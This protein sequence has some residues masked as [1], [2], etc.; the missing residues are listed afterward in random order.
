[1]PSLASRVIAVGDVSHR[2]LGE[3]TVAVNLRSGQYHSLNDAA[4]RML[5]E[6]LAGPTVGAALDRL[7]EIYDAPR[8]V[9]ESDLL[10]L[11]DVLAER[12]L[13]DFADDG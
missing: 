13:V 7:E 9:L 6:L 1:M 2:R 12:G 10:E 5:D 11:C 4:G 3:E 8:D